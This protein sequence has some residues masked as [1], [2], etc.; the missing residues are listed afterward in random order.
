MG[1]ADRIAELERQLQAA[2]QE[3]E[4]EVR[5]AA[6]EAERAQKAIED[7]AQLLQL[8]DERKRAATY[9][10]KR[11]FQ[12]I[13]AAGLIGVVF[14]QG[15]AGIKAEINP[16]ADERDRQIAGNEAL[17]RMH[18]DEI[19]RL[20]ERGREVERLREEIMMAPHDS[21]CGFRYL[22]DGTKFGC[23]C[24]KSDILATP[25]ATPP[26]SVEDGKVCGENQFHGTAK[27]VPPTQEHPDTARLNDVIRRA[28]APMQGVTF[29]RKITTGKWQYQERDDE[30]YMGI[31]GEGETQRDAIDNAA[32]T[33]PEAQR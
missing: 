3:R 2:Q 9:W 12:F 15:A 21:D 10:H 25:A 13:E 7:R 6:W 16:S 18:A 8:A 14:S 19:K 20:D 29:Y 5:N 31:C 23:H 22:A 32:R 24:W 28:N 17:L 30:G 11:G 27:M 26:A 1:S 33:A 4:Y